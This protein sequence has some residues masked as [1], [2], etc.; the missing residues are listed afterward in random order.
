MLKNVEGARKRGEGTAEREVG[1]AETIMAS[2][3]RP[4]S[5]T[6]TSIDAK[7]D[8]EAED[9]HERVVVALEVTHELPI[10][11]LHLCVETYVHVRDQV[12]ARHDSA[13]LMPGYTCA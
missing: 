7:A 3:S 13:C 10:P 2:I 4:G 12:K 8:Q 1:G 9:L 5:S 6:P 11:H